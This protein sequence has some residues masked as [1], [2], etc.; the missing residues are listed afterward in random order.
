MSKT[1]LPSDKIAIVGTIKPDAHAAGTVSSVWIDASKFIDFLAIVM[2]GT[3]GASATLDFKIEQAKDDTGTD[4]KD[5]SGA[6]VTQLTQ[7]G[8][9]DNK[10][11]IVQFS[12]EDLDTNNDFTHVRA[13]LTIGTATSDAGATLLAYGGRYEPVS[14]HDADSVKEIVTA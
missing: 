4:A 8:G 6:A 1:L 11:A 9:D 7:A 10:Q 13:S 3:L 2:A 12:T 5:L 14:D